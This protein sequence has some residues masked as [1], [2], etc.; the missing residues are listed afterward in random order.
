MMNAEDT[1]E[2]PSGV[3]AATA[4]GEQEDDKERLKKDLE[5]VR[6][7]LLISVVSVVLW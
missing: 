3:R 4:D 1:S 7:V 2:Q 5:K 6:A